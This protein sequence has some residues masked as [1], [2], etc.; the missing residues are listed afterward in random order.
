MASSQVEPLLIPRVG[1]EV[2]CCSHLT[3]SS[4]II[5]IASCQDI[6]KL[7]DCWMI[8]RTMYILLTVS[9]YLYLYPTTLYL[10]VSVSRHCVR[11]L[12]SRG[13]PHYP[14]GV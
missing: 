10:T 4:E 3:I 6:W 14:P 11:T 8:Y 1:D 9:R 2:T 13:I 12:N 5:R 7:S